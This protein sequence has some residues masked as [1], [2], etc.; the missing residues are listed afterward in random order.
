MLGRLF[1]TIGR[2]IMIASTYALSG[3][4]LAVTGYLFSIDALSANAQTAAWMIV[5]FFAVGRSEFCVSDGQ[6]MFSA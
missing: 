6:R 4:L 3:I 1:D 5:F 2:R